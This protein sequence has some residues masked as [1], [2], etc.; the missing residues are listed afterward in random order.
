MKDLILSKL[1]CF[2]DSDFIFDPK[3]HK[4]TYHGEQFISVTKYIQ[5]FHKPFETDFWSKKKAE[6][7]DL[8]NNLAVK[9]F[10]ASYGAVPDLKKIALYNCEL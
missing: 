10:K 3:Y 2:N 1:E 7:R 5:N 4:Y 9:H 8:G 6:Q